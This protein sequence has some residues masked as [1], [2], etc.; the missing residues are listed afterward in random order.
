M[1][2]HDTYYWLSTRVAMAV[3]LFCVGLPCPLASMAETAKPAEMNRDA[4]TLELHFTPA[5]THGTFQAIGARILNVQTWAA[6][7]TARAD[8]KGFSFDAGKQKGPKN[9]AGKRQ[10]KVATTVL[11][12]LQPQS[13]AVL[14]I[15]TNAGK[16]AVSLRDIG[17]DQS[18]KYLNG[19]VA[20]RQLPSATPLAVSDSDNDYPAATRGRDGAVWVAF[21]AYQHG[22]EPDMAAAQKDEFG[23][24]VPSGN[25]DQ[26]R[27]VKFDGKQWSAPMPVTEPLLDLWKPTVAVD[28]AGKVWV[29]WS[30]NSGD[31]WDIYRR[32]YDPAS[33]PMV[34]GRADDFRAGADINLVSATDSKGKV[35]WAWQGR[36]EKNF[37][38][39][40]LGQSRGS[41]PIAVTAN[42]ANHWDPAIAADSKGN[43]YVAWDSYENGNY[44]VFMQRFQG[45]EPQGLIPV[46]TTSDYETRV[47]LA[48]DGQ[49]RVWIGYEQG[50]SNWGKDYGRMVPVATGKTSPAEIAAAGAEY[51]AGQGRPVTPGNGVG[52]PLYAA[53]RVMVK[54]Y[55]DG[56]M[57]QPAADPSS[58]WSELTRPKSF[59]RMAVA[60]DGRLWLLFRHHPLPTGV[61]ETWAEYAM[62]Y[63][64]KAWGAPR[65]LAIPITSW[66]IGRPWSP[67]GPMECWPSTA[68]IIACGEPSMWRPRAR[69]R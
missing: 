49:D 58:A 57:Q 35:W 7:R 40:L 20:V 51:N 16:A 59:A 31:N 25:G 63:D 60:G 37:Q 67:S 55:A 56:R 13:D 53:R 42:P 68:A 12:V 28:G 18:K 1:R 48:V 3:L 23:S 19:E 61:R 69:G 52:I 9:A 27:L 43:V 44:D 21:V 50:G 64:G 30:Q 5:V 46:A 29:A 26:I 8:A 45:P 62:S 41:M 34:G 38:I 2:N 24:L 39:F 66:T 11:A 54:C 15:D 10:P 36:R 4:V 14:E 33:Q 17:F 65:R 32:S 6:D 22:G 47:S